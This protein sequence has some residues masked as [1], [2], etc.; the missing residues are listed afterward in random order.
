VTYEAAC[1]LASRRARIEPQAVG[2]HPDGTF[3]AVPV[4]ALRKVDDARR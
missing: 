1:A 2:Q 4:T 3:Y